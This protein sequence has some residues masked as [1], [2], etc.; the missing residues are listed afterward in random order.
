MPDITLESGVRIITPPGEWVSVRP[1]AQ[2]T[3]GDF[4]GDPEWERIGGIFEGDLTLVDHFTLVAQGNREN[5]SAGEVQ[6][7]IEVGVSDNEGS[8]VLLEQD[9]VYMWGYPASRWWQ[10]RRESF[11]LSFD[12]ISKTFLRGLESLGW[13]SVRTWVFRFAGRRAL[14]ALVTVKERKVQEGWIHI[15][16]EDLG[17]WDYCRDFR[18]CDAMQRL[19]TRRFCS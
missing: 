10:K 12:S 9:G 5:V 11:S 16:S 19:L 8:V 1:G 15:K 4:P 6:F 18:N 7:T 14:K 3:E 2:R 17:T 13:K